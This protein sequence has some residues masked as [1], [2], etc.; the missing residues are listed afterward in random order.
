MVSMEPF[1]KSRHTLTT[2]HTASEV[3]EHLR[4]TF[5][6][7]NLRTLGVTVTLTRKLLKQANSKA[8]PWIP[9]SQ[10]AAE[11]E[12]LDEYWKTAFFF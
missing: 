11:F 2:V 5:S 9:L 12:S 6:K 4:Q 7:G 1:P 3:H 10:E 8:P